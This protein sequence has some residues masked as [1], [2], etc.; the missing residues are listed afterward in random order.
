MICKHA[1]IATYTKHFDDGDPVE[2]GWVCECGQEFIPAP[3]QKEEKCGCRNSKGKCWAGTMDVCECSCHKTVENHDC[4]GGFTCVKCGMGSLDVD[5]SSC[6]GK[7]DTPKEEPSVTAKRETKIYGEFDCYDIDRL[8]QNL[9]EEE[10]EWRKALLDFLAASPL[11]G[12]Y[13]QDQ[14]YDLRKRFL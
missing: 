9:R 14:I 7:P 5:F 13:E 2:K 3:T 10:R 8:F 11:A 12:T 1:R 6:K 4:N